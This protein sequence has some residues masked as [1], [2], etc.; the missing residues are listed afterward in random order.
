MTLELLF[1]A[2]NKEEITKKDRAEVRSFFRKVNKE[3][4]QLQKFRSIK[5]Y[6]SW[7]EEPNLKRLKQKQKI[8][9]M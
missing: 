6:V 5:T 3:N 1:K 9:Q 7:R 2:L 4:K 8:H